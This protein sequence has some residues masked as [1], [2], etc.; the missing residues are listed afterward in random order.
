MKNIQI[1]ETENIQ[2]NVENTI[3]V[4]TLINSNITLGVKRHEDPLTKFLQIEDCIL[5]T[6][7]VLEYPAKEN[8]ALINLDPSFKNKKTIKMLYPKEVLIKNINEYNCKLLT[9]EHPSEKCVT[10]NTNIGSQ[11]LGLVLNNSCIEE[12]N[13]E[14]FVKNTIEFQT[15]KGKNYIINAD[16]NLRNGKKGL[17]SGYKDSQILV[18]SGEYKGEKYDLILTD[19]KINHMG[20]TWDPRDSRTYINNSKG[21]NMDEEVQKQIENNISTKLEKLELSFKEKLET[22][23][24][25][26]K[27][28]SE[29]IKMGFD[30]FK[31]SL[32]EKLKLQEVAKHVKVNGTVLLNSNIDSQ[33][34]IK[35]ELKAR[36]LDEYL[37]KSFDLQITAIEVDNKNIILNNSKDVVLKSNEIPATTEIVTEIKPMFEFK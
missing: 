6:S 35:E 3:G 2:Y 36:K 31:T 30:N 8:P 7:G 23:T 16:K 13:G 5:A 1:N 34:L 22:A 29:K 25:S 17:S 20:L 12:V 27:D 18:K 4:D 11:F 37:E 24:K 14:V 10:I 32:S 15:S 19:F 26:F 9:D 21:K 28:E 33:S